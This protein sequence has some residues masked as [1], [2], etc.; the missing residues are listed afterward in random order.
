VA[1]QLP[2]SL[3]IVFPEASHGNWGACGN[4]IWADF[5]DRGTVQ[6]LDVSCVSAQKPT[7]FVIGPK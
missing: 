4:R 5:I 7:K 6:G 3:H 1:K 2:N